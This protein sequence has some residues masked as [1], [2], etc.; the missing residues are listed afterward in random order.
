[1]APKASPTR[2]EPEV[3]IPY[4]TAIA[5]LANLSRRLFRERLAGQSWVAEAGLKQ[6]CYGAMTWINRLEPVSQKRVAT[7]LGRDPSDIVEVVDI[8]ERAGFVARERDTRDRRRYSLRL[9]PKGRGALA[10]LDAIAA[11]VE[12][13]ALGALNPRE[14]AQF[15]Q[16][17]RRV[18]SGLSGR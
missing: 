10:R 15:E 14:R 16:L 9:T 7:E 4:T 6:G 3:A 12:D 18:F 2:T 5:G 11:D 17:V 8:L 1:V 13:E